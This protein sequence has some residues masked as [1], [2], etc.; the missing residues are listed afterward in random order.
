[1][2]RE[3]KK[4]KLLILLGLILLTSLVFGCGYAFAKIG[5]PVKFLNQF[6]KSN[7]GVTNKI[8]NAPT[9]TDQAAPQYSVLIPSPPAN[10]GGLHFSVDIKNIS[11]TPF[12]TGLRFSNCKFVDNKSNEYGGGAHGN[13]VE[14]LSFRFPKALLPGEG[15]KIEFKQ[16]GM[17]LDGMGGDGTVT[18]GAVTNKCQYDSG[19]NY[20][21][22]AIEGIKFKEC[23]ISVST[24]TSSNQF[25]L[26]VNF[27]Q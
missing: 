15:S 10:N 4:K 18:D 13:G 24:D 22:T 6:W 21:C 25:P 8:T 26:V 3:N 17:S 20:V 23:T 14:H 11:V 2:I 5:N 19:G 16:V 7:R 27:P 12:I 9:K 1:M